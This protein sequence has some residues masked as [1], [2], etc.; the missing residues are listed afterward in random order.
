MH[1]AH[2]G[3]GDEGGFHTEEVRRRQLVVIADAEG[4][5][6]AGADIGIGCLHLFERMV[7]QAGDAGLVQQVI[8]RN[9]PGHL[10]LQRRRRGI[11]LDL[12]VQ[13]DLSPAEI[14]DLLQRRN[15]RTGK[16][17]AEEAAGIQRPD[18]LIG[19]IT[20]S[21]VHAGTALQGG[22]VADHHN[23]V[24]RH[25]DIQ[26]N[27]VGPDID[28][29]L[30][31]RQGIL[32]CRGTVAPVTGDAGPAE[33]IELLCGGAQR[34]QLPESDGGESRGTGNAERHQKDQQLPAGRIAL[35]LRRHF[36]GREGADIGLLVQHQKKRTGGQ[37]T[38]R[39][40]HEGKG[41]KQDGLLGSADGGQQ[42]RAVSADQERRSH[43]ERA[44]TKHDETET[45]GNAGIVAEEHPGIG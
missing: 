33:G 14:D 13:L 6:I 17:R 43:T 11:V 12:D 40:Q 29:C 27:A 35:L 44:V 21:P 9:E 30:K 19:H 8:V 23:P 34:R 24:L 45:D 25:L 38:E 7:A 1:P 26:F 39:L 31:G 16:F 10:C 41:R 37:G 36:Q 3:G 2:H 15:F 22:I 42:L 5:D 32:G 18:L 4:Q 20:D 28:G